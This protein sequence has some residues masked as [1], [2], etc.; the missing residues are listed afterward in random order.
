MN[1]LL[2]C[3]SYQYETFTQIGGFF[4][5]SSLR[6]LGLA[7]MKLLFM[8]VL[9]SS[10]LLA[11]SVVPERIITPPLDL[12]SFRNKTL[13]NGDQVVQ[14]TKIDKNGEFSS[15]GGTTI[16][17]KERYQKYLSSANGVAEMIPSQSGSNEEKMYRRGTAFSIGNNLVL[18]NLHVLDSNFENTSECD[19]FEI[20]NFEGETFDCKKVHYCNI[21]QDVCLIEMKNKIKT[22]RDCLFCPGVKYE[23][24]LSQSP[25]L[26]LFGLLPEGSTWDDTVTTAIGNSAGLGIHYSQ[27]RGLLL[28]AGQLRFYAP[29][30]TGNSGGPLLSENGHVIGIVKRQTAITL[31]TDPN[32]SYNIATPVGDF[33]QAV[34][35]NLANHPEVLDKFNSSVVE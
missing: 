18:T 33:I 4:T 12:Y 27:G 5:K 8:V 14:V 31:S 9:Y 26:K 16:L 10:T 7:H 23:V 34:R 28:R 1:F 21:E 24:S 6:G 15:N 11:R 29:I 13:E 35:Q 17:T 32:K 3:Q 30:T 25:S 20:K 2:S 19:D 22:K